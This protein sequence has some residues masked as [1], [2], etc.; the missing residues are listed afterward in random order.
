MVKVRIWPAARQDGDLDNVESRFPPGSRTGEGSASLHVFLEAARKARIQ[1]G[2]AP[3]PQAPS[4]RGP[5]GK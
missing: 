5:S 2:P 4:R 3:Q 1:G